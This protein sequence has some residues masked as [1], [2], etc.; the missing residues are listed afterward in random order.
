MSMEQRTIR[1]GRV[2]I[3]DDQPSNILLLERTLQQAGFAKVRST[4]DSQAV[5][6]IFTEFQPDIL[7]LDLHMPGLNGF[8]VMEQLNGIVGSENYLPILVL[9][10]DMSAPMKQ[11]ALTCGAKDFL[12]KPLDLMEVVLRIKNLLE[13]RFLHLQLQEHNRSLEET[14][15][16]RTKEVQEQATQLQHAQ[17]MEGIGMLAGGVAHDFNNLLTI[18][19][20]YSEMVIGRMKPDDPSRAMI[21]QIFK[22]G[23]R[24][25][26]LTRQLLAFSRKQILQV[27]IL[28]L[29]S[30]IADAEKMLSRL[31][32]ENVKIVTESDPTLGHVKADAGQIEQI[33]LNLCVNARDAMPK[34]GRITIV[35]R[36][37]ELDDG[38]AREHPYVKPG[39][40]VLLDV[41][42]TGA[43]MDEATKARL[44]EPF[45]T[46]KELGKGTGLGL[47]TVYGIVKQSGGSIECD[48][49]IGRGTRF[50]IYLP[51]V[52]QVG[53]ASKS[54]VDESKAPRGTETLLVVDDEDEVRSLVRFALQSFGYQVLDAASGAE[55]LMLS[56]AHQTAI[57]LLVTDVVMPDMSGRELAD[58]LTAL[59]PNLKVLYVSGYTDDAIILNGVAAGGASFLAKPI[60]PGMLARKVRMVL[61]GAL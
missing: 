18:I 4:T 29:N 54:A 39:R 27:Q 40:F 52:E 46:T 61:D 2:L 21:Q 33:L 17:R 15:R 9:T 51:R 48:S 47:A 19:S 58:R 6:P 3:V 50:Q 12:T 7:L 30:L 25:T 49:E 1:S 36:N 43:G 56:R 8:E 59:R 23:E 34:G 24:A 14:V 35:T 11:R 32:G 41:R 31:I 16:E 57:H 38:Y 55:A 28:D 37:V 44:F 45:F 42:D 10:A 53:S 13:T 20:G 22:A 60:T 26:T 5:L